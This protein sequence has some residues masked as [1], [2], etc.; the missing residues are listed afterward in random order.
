M[1][2]SVADKNQLT[3]ETLA[4]AF[5]CFKEINKEVIGPGEIKCRCAF[6]LCLK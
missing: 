6:F 1:Q 3:L 5:T 2:A 4:K